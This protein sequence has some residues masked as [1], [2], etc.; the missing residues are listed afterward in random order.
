LKVASFTSGRRDGNARAP[1]ALTRLLRQKGWTGHPATGE[2]VHGARVQVVPRLPKESKYRHVD[3]LL[4]EEFG[5]PL[6]IFTADCLPIFVAADRGRVVGILHAG[7]RG[8]RAGILRRAVR[9]LKKR[10]AIAP[11][12]IT[13]WAGPAIRPCC[14]EVQW[15]VARYF[16]RSR[17]RI[18]DR[19]TVDLEREVAAQAHRLGI[20]WRRPVGANTC[21][22]HRHAYFSYRRDA[23]SHRQVSAIIKVN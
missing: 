4:T 16:P 23:T 20:R 3:G 22:M 21:T 2:Q 14:F 7:W 6:G 1:G 9:I 19:W 5:Q 10:W 11:R 12:A 8:I 17:R 15:D 18:R 13:A